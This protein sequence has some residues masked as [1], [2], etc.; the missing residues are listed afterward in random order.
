MLNDGEKLREIFSKGRR[1]NHMIYFSSNI[2]VNIS[3]KCKFSGGSV[4]KLHDLDFI[5]SI[6]MYVVVYLIKCMQR[7]LATAFSS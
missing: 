5:I 6:Y 4:K 3:I 1:I 2:I 7:V